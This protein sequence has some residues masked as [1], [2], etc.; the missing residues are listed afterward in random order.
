[1]TSFEVRRAEPVRRFTWRTG[2][3]HRPGLA[4]MVSTGLQVGFESLEEAKLLLALDFLGGITTLLCQPFWL[5]FA[6][7]EGA[8]KHAPMSWR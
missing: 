7:P 5:H 1:M 8:A 3:R 6:T 2:Q 4:F